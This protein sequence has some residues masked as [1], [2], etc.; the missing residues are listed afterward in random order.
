[1]RRS[2]LHLSADERAQIVKALFENPNAAAVSRELGIRK[3]T[4]QKIAREIKAGQIKNP[5]A[6]EFPATV[7][8]DIPV[9][10]IIDMMA[11]RAEKRFEAAKSREWQRIK[12]NHDRPTVLAFTGDPHLDDDGTNWPL[13]KKHIEFLKQP[14]V[15]A[16]N[17]GDTTNSWGGKLIR[18]YANQETSKKTARKL[19]KWFLVDSG[20]NWLVWLA[21]NHEEMDASFELFRLMNTKQIVMEEW[22]ARFAVE[23]A[24]GF[25][26]PIWAAHDFKYKSQYNILHGPQRA[27][28]ERR[29]ASIYVAGHHHTWGVAQ[30]ELPDTGEVFWTMRARGYKTLDQYA[31]RWGFDSKR[32][33]ATVAAV[34]DPKNPDP[35]TAIHCFADL[36]TAVKFKNSI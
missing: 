4:V 36:E 13:L 30:E 22:Q 19:A 23:W 24:G 29:G 17:I 27:A 35:L 21:G 2:G 6:V 7:D 25:S 31:T 28:R 1:M 14:D 8:D 20:I 10:Q 5:I 33:G 9:D 34:V 16:I 11:R 18:L 32:Y 12:I 3:P 26:V 15:Y